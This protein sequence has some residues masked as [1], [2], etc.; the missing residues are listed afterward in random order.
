MIA[1]S[2]PHFKPGYAALAVATGLISDVLD[3]VAARKLDAKSQFGAAFDQLADL[4]CFG[5]GPA[6]F[7]IRATLDG[8]PGFSNYEVVCLI[9]G[10]GYMACSVARIARELVV[11]NMSR[12]LFFVGIPTNLACPILVLSTLASPLAWWLPCLAVFL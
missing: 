7:Y 2:L 10:F 5:I 8:K 4:T 12:P 9:T 6:V 3:G 11:T 1:S